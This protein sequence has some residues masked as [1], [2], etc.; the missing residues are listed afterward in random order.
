MSVVKVSSG[1]YDPEK[2][3]PGLYPGITKTEQSI[4]I[5][6]IQKVYSILCAQLLL[7][8]VV[9]CAIYFSPEQTRNL[10]VSLPVI[11]SSILSV[12]V[13]I[14]VI[15]WYR[16]S[17]PINLILL[18][19]WTGSLSVILGTGVSFY[20]SPSVFIAL[21]LT[22][23]ATLSLT[24]YTFTATSKGKEFDALG[25]ILSSGLFVLVVYGF[26]EAFFPAARVWHSVFAVLGTFVFIGYIVLDTFDII[27]R[28]SIDDYVWASMRLYL[29][30]TNLFLQILDL[31][32]KQRGS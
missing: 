7:T 19:I 29:D 25:P 3:Q 13:L 4:R 24:V 11:I 31:V 21:A 2:A 20:D 17:H 15:Y 9:S 28:Y 32:G 26:I 5:G 30:V 10:F 8:A 18:A 22:V 12:F 6:F 27:K 1:T 16:H 23:A 14:P